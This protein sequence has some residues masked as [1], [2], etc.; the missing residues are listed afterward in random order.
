MII[1]ISSAEY[2]YADVCELQ[3]LLTVNDVGEMPGKLIPHG[4]IMFC[5]KQVEQCKTGLSARQC[6]TLPICEPQ[7]RRQW[8]TYFVPS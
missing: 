6:S 2:L 7:S 8:L 4:K 5:Q 3:T 1:C